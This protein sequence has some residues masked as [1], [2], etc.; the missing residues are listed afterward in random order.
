MRRQ[1]KATATT[2]RRKARRDDKHDAAEVGWCGSIRLE[3]SPLPVT[4]RPLNAS[5]VSMGRQSLFTVQCVS[6]RNM[7]HD[8]MPGDRQPNAQIER[9][10]PDT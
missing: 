1:E 2:T 8:K 9:Q 5:M 7:K 10:E 6:V 4:A 3:V